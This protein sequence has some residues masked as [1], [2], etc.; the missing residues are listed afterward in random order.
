VRRAPARTLL[1]L[2]CVFACA[3]ALPGCAVL[4]RGGKGPVSPEPVPAA[5]A[6]QAK[7][8]K[9]EKRQ[10]A[11]ERKR[12][13]EEEKRVA[14][15]Q[16]QAEKEARRLAKADER[17]AEEAGRAAGSEAE[18]PSRGKPADPLAEAKQ[19]AVEQPAEPWWPYRM[20]VLEAEAGNAP[21]SEAALRSALE[22]DPA[23]A[24][25]LTRLSRALF[26]QGRHAEAVTLLTPV[27]EQRVALS[28]NERAAVLAGLALHEAAL[29]REAEARGAL[30]ALNGDARDAS[31][32]VAAYLA[33]RSTS[34]NDAL[35][36]TRA[37]VRAAPESAA[38]QNNLGIAL[39]RSGDVSGAEKAFEKAISLDPAR[40]GP[41]YNLAIL[42]RFY[43]LDTDAASRRFRDYWARSQADP[44]SLRNELLGGRTPTA[45][46]S[47]DK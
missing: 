32:G 1:A 16:K 35:N 12:L 39:L 25:A 23:Y 34:G 9:E 15:E 26:E 17:A 38:Q 2:A 18:K 40:P 28:G 20:A 29:G 7:P 13:R 3:L 24:P 8:T 30:A 45:E 10:A 11:L 6:E 37:A 22:R 14:A 27:R 5:S 46:G 43:H 41:Y 21:A 42:E 19:K 33:V 47:R 36:L 44:D 31:L 4:G